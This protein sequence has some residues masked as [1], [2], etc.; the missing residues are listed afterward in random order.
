M[1]NP[2]LMLLD[3]VSLGLAP[4]VIKRIYEA[5]GHRCSRAPPSSW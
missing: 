4:V 2:Q 3:E 1:S 5:M